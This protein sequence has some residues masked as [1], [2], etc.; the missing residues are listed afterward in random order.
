MRSTFT[1]HI[2]GCDAR[3]M[4]MLLII[5]G[6]VLR[7]GH[8]AIDNR[9]Q[10]GRKCMNHEQS[11]TKAN[12]FF[13]RPLNHLSHK[14]CIT[15][16]Y[17]CFDSQ[18]CVTTSSKSHTQLMK[19]HYTISS[20]SAVLQCSVLLCERPRFGNFLVFR[21]ME[22]CALI[23]KI[24]IMVSHIIIMELTWVWP[25]GCVGGLAPRMCTLEYCGMVEIRL[26]A[27]P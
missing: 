4:C 22:C 20:K 16:V 18:W 10:R 21:F 3:K 1:R 17:F 7:L 24:E 15:F 23:T 5:N 27:K 13:A 25:S 12:V 19:H 2:D 6:D 9:M 14:V 8:G 26:S 11:T